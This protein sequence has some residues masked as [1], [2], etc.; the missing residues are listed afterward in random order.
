MRNVPGL[1]A[2]ERHYAAKGVRFY[3]IYKALAHPE[4]NGFISPFTLEERLMHVREAKQ[5]LGTR[6]RWLC[7]TM[8]NDLKHALGD[9]PN[10][11]FVIDPEGRVVRKRGLEQS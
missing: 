1:E 4:I 3:Y 11:E 9:R 8:D 2:I 5:R 7:D 10:S 6:F